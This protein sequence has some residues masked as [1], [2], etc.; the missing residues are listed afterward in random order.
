MSKKY[1]KFALL[2]LVLLGVLVFDLSPVSA[3]KELALDG[4]AIDELKDVIDSKTQELLEINKKIAETQLKITEV[5]GKGD[6]IENA[7]AQLDYEITQLNYGIRSSEISI[8]KLV[9]E[10]ESLGYELGDVKQDMAKKSAIVGGLLREM[11]QKDREGLLELFLRNQS[12]ADG[13]F[14]YQGIKVIQDDLSNEVS[15]LGQIRDR[16]DQ[17][18]NLTDQKKTGLENENVTL[19]SR[20]S[21]AADQQDEKDRL[22]AMN[23]AEEGAYQ[24]ALQQLRAQQQSIMEEIN[25]I[26]AKLKAGFDTSKAPVRTAGRLSWPLG[27][28]VGRITQN[29]GETAYAYQFYKGKPHNGTDIGAPIGTPVYAA[30][31]GTVARADNNGRYQYGRYI[32]I[33][34]GGGLSTLY[35]HLSGQVVSSGQSVKRGDLIGYVGSTGFSTG[36]HLHFGAYATPSGGWGTTDSRERGGFISLP[37]ASGLVPVGVTFDAMGYL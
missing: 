18:I 13:M 17:T 11:Q 31:D 36:P 25:S 15:G 35:A 5:Q 3:E 32:M 24:T 14:E 37:P 16:L 20:K 8:D 21:I 6:T 30:A 22:L 23:K 2:S 9:L 27:E 28:G 10:L 34:H 4:E 26:E 29:Y 12:L 19:R 33:D 7:I 1:S